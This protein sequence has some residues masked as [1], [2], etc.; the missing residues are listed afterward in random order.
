MFC[1]GF[2][3]VHDLCLTQKSG[4]FTKPFNLAT[5]VISWRFWWKYHFFVSNKDLANTVLRTNE[6]YVVCFY[7]NFFENGVRLILFK[8]V[9]TWSGI[10]WR[11]ENPLFV[12]LLFSIHWSTDFALIYLHFETQLTCFHYHIF[13]LNPTPA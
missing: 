8:E 2:L 9:H 7:F 11:V 13:K 10:W 5:A 12:M 1:T 4:T 6:L 3:C